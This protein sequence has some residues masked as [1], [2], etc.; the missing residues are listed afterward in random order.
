VE[1]E[2]FTLQLFTPGSDIAIG[3]RP[4]QSIFGRTGNDVLLGYQP[5]VPDSS[6]PQVDFLFGD[7]ALDD[8]AFRE[9]SDTFILG[10]W[11]RPY[12]AN[13]NPLQ[14]GINDI[15]VIPD[16]DPTRDTI[17][18]Y[19][20]ADDYQL[21]EIGSST[22]ILLQTENGLDAVGFLLGA[23]DLD[24]S[25]S[26]FNFRGTTPPPG[27]VLPNVK[28]F[29]TR[30]FD[31]PLS[32]STDPDGNFY[33]AGGT[34]GSLAE[35]NEGLRDN[36]VTKYDSQ[37]NEL[38]TL[39]F[40]TSG[41][42]TIYGIDTDN[43]GN[44]YVTG[45]TDSEL[46]GPKQADIIDT[47]VAKYD[48]DGNQ[49][50]I[51]QIGQ[52]VIFNAFNIAV[53]KET[54]DVYISGADVQNSIENPDDAFIIKF[55]T[56]GEQQWFTKTGTS[57][58]INFDETYGLT[59]A[60][61]GSVYATGWTVGDLGGPNQGLYDNWI[62][63]YNEVT[64]EQEWVTQYGTDD[65]EWSWDVQTDSQGNVYT[66]GWTL[67]SLEGQ[68]AGSYDAYL[69]K[70][71]S[72]GNQ[73]WVQQFGTPGDDEAYS[74]FIDDN[75]NVFL[76]GYTDDN[77][78]G[79]NAGSFDAWVARYDTN[80]NQEWIT[81]FGTPDRDELY[82]L[83][84]DGLGNLYVTGITQGSLG[85]TNA[86]S[87]DGWAAK[88]N[89]ES[90]ALLDFNGGSEPLDGSGGQQTFTI[91]ASG[92]TVVENFKGV[93]TGNKPSA[94][95][96]AEL[97]TLKFS[98][99]GLTAKNMRLA[100]KGDDLEISFVGNSAIKVTLKDFNLQNLDNLPQKPGLGNILFDGQTQI[101]DSF[102][103]FDS[104]SR[105][106]GIFNRNTVTFLNNRN[107][108]VR[109]FEKS[110]D[111][112]NGQDGDDTLYGL[113]GNDDLRGGA[114]KDL[115]YGG[116]GLDTLT[117]DDG[118]DTFALVK[119]SGTDTITDFD[120][121]EGDRLGLSSGLTFQQLTITQGTG[122]NINNTLI[123]LTSNQELLAVLNGVQANSL[124]NAAFTSIV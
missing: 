86:G 35:P 47:F 80:G 105:Q 18:L 40:G 1:D 32:A 14:F 53:D 70:Y 10:D 54:G 56:E 37:G 71:D 123:K 90:G 5:P 27:P 62:A 108:K 61:D 98:G 60:D 75:D 109:G 12:Y 31:I 93:G 96:I 91:A 107:N 57:G 52:N 69:T 3:F 100:Q 17:Q 114:G 78:G 29:G 119:A 83:S 112:I 67:G 74:L 49:Q 102:D 116:T 64:G 46:A 66:A 44:F 19:G 101:K 124:T 104:N 120:L 95:T 8:P 6:Q 21:I 59:V 113:S 85:A 76:A 92:T 118:A 79:T 84:A 55:D 50:W 87:F 15:G 103:V 110:D 23:S 48:S 81:Q 38:F 4:S 2:L 121:S 89:A 99:A 68:N 58:F 20:S 42:D 82:G 28:Q 36:F 11:E 65:Y 115:L 73:I 88:L 43:E 24:L 72:E 9:W 16:F 51:K 33:V 22:A 97:D 26:Y 13:G 30:E 34:N 94:Q 111:V 39:Q 63:K 45:I 77:L 7:F 122:A 25:E 41:F 117:G 106:G